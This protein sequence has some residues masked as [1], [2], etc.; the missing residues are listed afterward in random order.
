MAK[1]KTTRTKSSGSKVLGSKSSSKSAKSLAA[2]ALTQK[3]GGLLVL[4]YKA[5][6]S[7]SAVEGM[8]LSKG[9]KADFRRLQGSSPSVRRDALTGKYG[10]K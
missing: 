4:G 1:N 9:M 5:F 6:A 3:S 10:K 7:I 8:Y 2:S